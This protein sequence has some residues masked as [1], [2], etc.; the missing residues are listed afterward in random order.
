MIFQ[1]A[2][3]SIPTPASPD[4]VISI[5][6]NELSGPRFMAF[7]Y[8]KDQVKR[9]SDTEAIKLKDLNEIQITVTFISPELIQAVY[10]NQIFM[11]GILASD[12]DAQLQTA[13]NSIAAREEILFLVTV[14]A[15]TNN[16]IDTV[17]HVID[18]PIKEMLLNNAGNLESIPG[19]DDHNLD[20]PI[21]SSLEP[22]FGYVAYPL[23]VLQS[24]GC[25]WVLD[26]KYNTNIVITVSDIKLDNISSHPYTWTIPYKPLIETNNYP[27]QSIFI[28][29][30]GDVNLISPL[31]MPPNPKM[32]QIGTDPDAYWQ[33][34]AR[35]VW[36]QITLG[37]Y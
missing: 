15:T 9:W 24:D 2:Y 14:T 37:N 16:S 29:V 10:L 6:P 3:Q 5:L 33:D 30:T 23:G 17:S 36:N 11:D 32:N 21:N 35:Y 22:V 19:H 34:F 7:Q 4:T 1:N 25:N 28:P 27:D 18:I 13:L 12:F 20:Q 8:L 26:P 31:A